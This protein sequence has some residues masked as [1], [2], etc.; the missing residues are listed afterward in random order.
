MAKVHGRER[1][2]YKL[3]MP[4]GDSITLFGNAKDFRDLLNFTDEIIGDLKSLD[5]FVVKEVD[6]S[7]GPGKGG[8]QGAETY[9]DR[10]LQNY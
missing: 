2:Y 9:Y 6:V 10:K 1:R 8:G 5:N 4:N 3:M 7:C